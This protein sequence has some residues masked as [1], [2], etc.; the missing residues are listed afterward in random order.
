MNMKQPKRYD[1]QLRQH[2]IEMALEISKI[3]NNPF[4]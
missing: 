3:V 1:D 2:A 4:L